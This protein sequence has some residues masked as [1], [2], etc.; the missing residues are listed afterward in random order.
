MTCLRQALA[1]QDM[2]GR[3]GLGTQLR[4]GVRKEAGD[5]LAHAWLEY[6]GQRVDVEGYV[7]ERFNAFVP[8]ETPR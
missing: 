7:E 2:L 5:L 4:L 3:R 8:L 6:Q 1:L